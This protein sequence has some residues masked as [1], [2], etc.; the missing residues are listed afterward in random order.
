VSAFDRLHPA[1]RH[2]VVNSLGWRDLRPVQ[3]LAI[4]AYLDGANLVV[5][6]PTAG[7][8]TE[9]AFFPIL[10]EM[11][12][13]S[14]AGLTVLY[15]SP[16]R[17][18]LNNQQERLA[19][20]FRLVGR[21]SACWHGDTSQSEKRRI[22]A[23]PPDCLLTTPES[24]EV[25]LVSTRIDQRQFFRSIRTV[26]IDELHAFAGDDRGWHLLSVLSRIQRLS[27]R[28]LQRAGLSA[29]VGNPSEMLEWLSCG[30]GR[31]RRVVQPP[32]SERKAPDVQID[33]V[34]SLANA[35]RVIGL[36]HRGE[37]RLVF[38]DSRSRVEQL[39]LLL[40]D[41]EI[42]TY[43]SHSSLGAEERRLAE[44]AFA[45][46]Q[47]CVIVATS[48]LELGID[49]GDLD[50]VI[51]IDAPGTVS[52]FL[53]RMGRTGRRAGSIAN[54]LFLA[55]SDEALLRAVALVRLWH[56]G[57]VEPV[58]A[59]LKP[60]HILAQ[61]LMA[62]C[63]QE[64]GIGRSEWCGWLASVPAFS[65]MDESIINAIVNSMIDSR[66]LWS[67]HGILSFAPEGE[68]RYGRKNFMELLSVFTSPPLFKVVCGRKELGFVHES[69]FFR[70]D[71]RPT[72]LLLTGRCWKA[73][74]LD[75]RRRIAHVE[76]TDQRGKSRWLGEGRFLGYEV[77][78]SIRE[79]L[80]GDAVDPYWSRRT[81]SRLGVMREEFPWI[82]PDS[83]ALVRHSDGEV[84]WW[85]FAGGVANAILSDTLKRYGGAEPDNA[86]IR[87]DGDASL[88]EVREHVGSLRNAEVVSAP[89]R[90]AIENLKFSEA[91]PGA[92]AEAVFCSRFC[93]EKAIRNVLA[94]PM[95]VV[96]E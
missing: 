23:D 34:G 27:G 67:D 48:S 79:I 61:Q 5:L 96:T 40:R 2:H 21:R 50:R 73:I 84:R 18:L 35:A 54:C 6:A 92:L 46:R 7:G 53:Q 15:V 30:S 14:W 11:L 90:R 31:A 49:V 62:I 29:T 94:E 39:A 58:K 68:A 12:T 78:Q 70:R 85:T 28:D 33:F 82:R 72:I 9:A 89:D 3:D 59:P 38:C 16:I 80:A 44:Q 13:E 56:R 91:L 65:H 22:V 24:L 74:H 1:L 69:T 75:W 88:D 60:Y 95:K 43:I 32:P 17:A 93:D 87:L 25:I 41:Q 10:S 4:D 47:D 45:G 8:K 76:P 37:K 57:F 83:T 77:C 42:E 36:L 81:N 20:Y 26:V 86:S 66:I 55:T 51:Q 19:R 63:L 52:S 71:E 64:R